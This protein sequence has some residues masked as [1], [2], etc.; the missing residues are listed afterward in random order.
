[1]GIED[2]IQAPRKADQ[3]LEETVSDAYKRIKD[4]EDQ[5][6]Q[7]KME[8][9][10]IKKFDEVKR[11]GFLTAKDMENYYTEQAKKTDISK[12]VQRMQE[13]EELVLRAKARGQIDSG[14]LDE[15]PKDQEPLLPELMKKPAYM[16][17]YERYDRKR[18]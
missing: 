11:L 13:L 18:R 4:E 2:D 10:A 15:Q 5:K 7:N 1:M 12:L 3:R 14:V 9:A 17:E 16:K 8:E 6:I